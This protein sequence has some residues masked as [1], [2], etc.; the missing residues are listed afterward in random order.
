MILSEEA[1]DYIVE[2]ESQRNFRSYG[3]M[4]W[5][6]INALKG[7]DCTNEEDLIS[8]LDSDYIDMTQ[9]GKLVF[10]MNNFRR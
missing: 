8:C 2:Y 9:E 4:T 1:R 7:W 3:E 6:E 10:I 5:H